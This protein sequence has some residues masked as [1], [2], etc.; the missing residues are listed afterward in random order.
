[1]P[2]IL[3]VNIHPTSYTDA[4]Q[5]IIHWAQSGESRMVCA[6]NVHMVMEAHDN[7][8]FKAILNGADLVTPDGMP[9]VWMLRRMGARRQ[10][11][12]YGPDLMLHVLAAAHAPGAYFEG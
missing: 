1:M 4:V 7:P 9:L 3:G 5:K 2:P 12:V 6:A 11:R 10:E 8:G